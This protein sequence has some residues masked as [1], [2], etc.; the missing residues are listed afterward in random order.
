MALSEER[1]AERLEA[2]IAKFGAIGSAI[3]GSN[4][5]RD[6]CPSCAEP[7]RR[8]VGDTPKRCTKCLANGHPGQGTQSGGSGPNGSWENIIRCHEDGAN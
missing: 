7:I 8:E 3:V 6:Y 4:L 1:Y 2:N 5:V